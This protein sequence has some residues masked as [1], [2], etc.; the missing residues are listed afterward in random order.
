MLY[1]MKPSTPQLQCAW[2]SLARG[3]I[4]A[5]GVAKAVVLAWA[6]G[7]LANASIHAV[8]SCECACRALFLNRMV[9]PNTLQLPGACNFLKRLNCSMDSCKSRSLGIAR[10][11]FGPCQHACGALCWMIMYGLFFF[12]KQSGETERSS[13]PWMS[14]KQR[15]QKHVPEWRQG[16]FGAKFPY[17]FPFSQNG[18]SILAL[19]PIWAQYHPRGIPWISGL[20]RWLRDTLWHKIAT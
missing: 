12:F 4:A 18:P 8:L 7:D 10:W 13:V 11:W 1:M 19:R 3:W 15:F 9:K 20:R 6:S 14:K 5:C 17:S 16:Y 2:W